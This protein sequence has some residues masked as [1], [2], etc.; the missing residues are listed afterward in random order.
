MK[1]PAASSTNISAPKMEPRIVNLFSLG[2][3]QG[4]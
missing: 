1:K 3:G 4:A 2:G